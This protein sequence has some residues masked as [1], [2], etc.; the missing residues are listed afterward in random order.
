MHKKYLRHRNTNE[1]MTFPIK[2]LALDA[3]IW[4]RTSFT[5]EFCCCSADTTRHLNKENVKNTC[6]SSED[7]FIRDFLCQNMIYHTYLH[8]FSIDLVQFLVIFV[9]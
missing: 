4:V 3:A 6:I 2:Y 9:F 5:R 8:C 1:T 7:V